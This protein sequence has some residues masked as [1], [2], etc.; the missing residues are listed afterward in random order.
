MFKT[1]KFSDRC[2]ELNDVLNTINLDKIWMDW[3]RPGLRSQALFDLH[4][5]YDFQIYRKD[6]ILK[7]VSTIF[8]GTYQPARPN[9]IRKE[10]HSGISRH[11]VVLQPEDALLLEALGQY[12]YPFVKNNSKSKNA[13]FS[14]KHKK[15]ASIDEIGNPNDPYTHQSWWE[16][17]P[18]FQN[19]ICG[20]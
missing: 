14:Q 8:D 6:K 17:W 11:L 12:L 19:K 18:I 20:F 3:V 13:F 1:Q 7:L 16:L 9:R 4:D 5:Y 10:K 15:N 2:K